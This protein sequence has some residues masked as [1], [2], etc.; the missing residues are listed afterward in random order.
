VE[1]TVGG[2]TK[3]KQNRMH[4]SLGI[5]ITIH[6]IILT[7]GKIHSNSD[8]MTPVCNEASE[9]MPSETKWI[10]VRNYQEVLP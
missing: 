8:S 9:S 6:T 3:H 5:S 4:S 2:Y 10:L 1:D 7:L